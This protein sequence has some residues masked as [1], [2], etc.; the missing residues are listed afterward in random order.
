MIVALSAS[1]T[2]VCV[3]AHVCDHHPPLKLPML[4]LPSSSVCTS[5][6]SVVVLSSCSVHVLCFTSSLASYPVR[7][8]SLL[9]PAYATLSPSD[10]PIRVSVLH[11]PL[12][13][14]PIPPIPLAHHLMGF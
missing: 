3:L 11:P 13:L 5:S 12:D 8:P 2:S 4:P 7:Y 9:L 10:T 14:P 1:S 6:P